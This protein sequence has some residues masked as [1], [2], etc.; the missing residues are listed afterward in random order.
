MNPLYT[1]VA[2]RAKYRYEYCRA[3]EKLFNDAFE[4]EQIHPRKRGGSDTLDNYA[5]SC[6]ICNAH[7]GVAQT[8]YDPETQANIALFHPRRDNWNDHFHFQFE[9]GEILGRTATG[10]ATVNRL[11][12]NAERQVA[13]RR[14][15][16]EFGYY[17]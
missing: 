12:L 14:L 8:G 13:A 15:W 5:L 3:P 16:M 9:T 1:P 6:C 7:K 2:A 4:V 11:Q 17:P 10:R